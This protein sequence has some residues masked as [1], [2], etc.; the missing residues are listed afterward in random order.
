MNSLLHLATPNIGEKA[1]KF[2]QWLAKRAPDPGVQVELDVTDER[3]WAPAWAMGATELR[4]VIADYLVQE[5]GYMTL[6][7]ASDPKIDVQISPRGWAHLYD[8]QDAPGETNLAFVAMWFDQATVDLRNQGVKP[9][10]SAAGFEPL[11]IDERKH[12]NPIDAEILATIRRSRLVVADLHGDRGGVY[13]EAGFARGLGIPVFWTCHQND[14]NDGLI[15]FDV[16]QH[17]FTAW[18]GS[19]WPAFSKRLQDL[20]EAVLGKGPI[21]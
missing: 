21:R 6:S 4:F 18:D 8:L 19:D 14:L 1:D 13:F 11:V 2:L 15:H 9:A 3:L 16:R 10:I 20:I 12:N 7:L 17:V 5:L